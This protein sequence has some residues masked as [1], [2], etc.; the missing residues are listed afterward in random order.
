MN[1]NIR[2]M[3]LHNRNYNIDDIAGYSYCKLQWR[4][5]YKTQNKFQN[6]QIYNL[7]CMMKSNYLYNLYKPPC[8]HCY[9]HLYKNTHI[10][11]YKSY[12]NYIHTKTYIHQYIQK[13]KLNYNYCNLNL[14]NKML[15]MVSGR[16]KQ[17]QE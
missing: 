14:L 13:R 8:N 9:N 12:C 15:K 7:Q 11:P 1:R 5:R 4:C 2:Y 3:N 16:K 10:L 6:N 17:C